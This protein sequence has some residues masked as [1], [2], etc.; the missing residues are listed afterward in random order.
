M[1]G[2]MAIRMAY[3]LQLHRELDHDPSGKTNDKSSELSFTDREI[4][5]RT[6]WACFLMDRFNSSGTARPAFA[7][8]ENIK[9]QLPI[10]ESNFRMEIPGPTEDLDGNVPYPI[11][12][13]EGHVADAKQNMGMAAYL[14]KVIAI[15]GRVVKYLNLG[16]K[17]EDS[18]PIWHPESGFSD[19]K[20]Q[21]RDFSESLPDKFRYSPETLQNFAAEKLGN[22]FLYLHIAYYQIILFLHKFAIPTT[23]GGKPPADLPPEFTAQSA[24]IAIDAASKISILLKEAIEHLVGYCAFASSTVHVWGIYSSNPR[25]EKASK[26][27]LAYNV[28]YMTRMK[29]HWGMFHHM[30]EN[31]KGIYRQY[32]DWRLQGSNAG[33]SGKHDAAL[34]QYGDWFDKYPHGVSGTDYEDPA[35]HEEEEES[36]NAPLS[37]KPDQQSV[38]DFFQS[39]AL[40]NPLPSRKM[41]RKQAFGGSRNNAHAQQQA[42]SKVKTEAISNRQSGFATQPQQIQDIS[43]PSDPPQQSNLNPDSFGLYPTGF[44]HQNPEVG[45]NL[46]GS[47]PNLPVPELD[48]HL[49]FGAYAQDFATGAMDPRM[50]GTLASQR[51]QPANPN[52]AHNQLATQGQGSALN[53]LLWD[54][55]AEFNMANLGNHGYQDGLPTSAWFMPFNLLPPEG[56]SDDNGASYGQGIGDI[57]GSQVFDT[58]QQGT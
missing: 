34:F 47:N 11:S 36:N 37:Q 3:A 48:R 53:P 29:K 6:M 49:V 43:V 4:R 10:K 44:Y 8:E 21:V 2:G 41:P 14:I 9:I 33:T 52:A 51:M 39:T 45:N 17:S 28:R 27:H 35:T 18:R 32:A 16:G 55:S 15:W 22:Q 38:E 30:V 7:S 25:L 50:A 24:E 23:P 57:D 1:F 40:N 12:T 20:R 56:T 54:Q 46:Y 58:G 5:R 42:A 13:G 31:L 26:Q 19:L